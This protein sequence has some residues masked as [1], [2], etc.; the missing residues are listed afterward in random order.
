MDDFTLSEVSQAQQDRGS[1]VW[2]IHGASRVQDAGYLSPADGKRERG[3][4][5][6][7]LN[8]KNKLFEV[9]H[10]LVSLDESQVFSPQ[11]P[12]VLR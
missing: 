2:H 6:L 5:K 7:H 3:R 9:P 12:Q 11:K 4:Q 1:E 10:C 8:G